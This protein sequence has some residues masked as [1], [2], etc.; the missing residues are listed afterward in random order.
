MDVLFFPTVALTKCSFETWIQT[1][2]SIPRMT[3][4]NTPLVIYEQVKFQRSEEQHI[5]IFTHT[6]TKKQNKTKHHKTNQH[7]KQTNKKPLQR[8][9]SYLEVFLIKFPELDPLILL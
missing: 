8:K 3:Q 5:W 2:T 7:T 9:E 4:M 1:Q 6:H